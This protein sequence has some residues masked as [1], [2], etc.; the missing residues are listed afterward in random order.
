[1]QWVAL[2]QKSAHVCQS[3]QPPSDLSR[4]LLTLGH[5][6][7]HSAPAAPAIPQTQP[8]H[9]PTHS[10]SC[11]PRPSQQ[12]RRPARPQTSSTACGCSRQRASAQCQVG[13]F[14]RGCWQA[15]LSVWALFGC[16]RVWRWRLN[17]HHTRTHA[18]AHTHTHTHTHTQLPC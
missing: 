17:H 12:P 8:T 14:C 10:S 11:P 6:C 7:H 15:L 13:S 3:C 4:S 2:N 1:V 18:R 5:L 9:Q 16:R